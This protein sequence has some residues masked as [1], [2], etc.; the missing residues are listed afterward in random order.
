MHRRTPRNQRGAVA[1]EAALV[2]PILMAVIFGIVE[3][4]MLVKDDIGITSATRQ[5]ARVASAAA[6]AGPGT[7]PSGPNAPTCTPASSP[8]F[9]QAAADAIQHSGQSLPGDLIKYILIYK[10]NKKGYPGSETATTMP[11]SCSGITACVKFIWWEPSDDF[12][13]DSGSWDSKSVNACVNEGDT[14]G[15]Y[16]LATHKFSTGLLGDGADL[17]DRAVMKFE[18]LD[19]DSCKPGTVTPHP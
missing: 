18:P 17:E 6:D 14:L 11:T 8:A 15:I 10:A 7:C 3:I 13:F 12:R 5:G 1:V 19:P 2:L 9:A 4:T 16:L